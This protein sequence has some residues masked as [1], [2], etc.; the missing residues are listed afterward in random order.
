[1]V[2]EKGTAMV[3][4]RFAVPSKGLRPAGAALRP[5]PLSQFRSNSPLCVNCEKSII[6]E[7]R[8]RKGCDSFFR[9]LSQDFSRN[10]TIR[11]NRAWWRLSCIGHHGPCCEKNY[12]E[13][14][15]VGGAGRSGWLCREEARSM[16]CS[17]WRRW[18]ACVGVTHEVEDL[19]GA[20]DAV[21]RQPFGAGPLLL[22]AFGLLNYGLWNAVQS[23][24][25]PE[26][27]GGDWLGN[28]LRVIFRMQRRLEYLSCLQD[29]GR[30]AG[31]GLEREDGV[32]KRFSPGRG[33]HSRCRGARTRDPRG[34]ADGRVATS[35]VVR[36]VRGNT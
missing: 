11:A 12:R 32:M 2:P 18:R 35:L 23:I 10:A 22:L 30:G 36:L 28:A 6:G 16:S 25:D 29:R 8:T 9:T 3:A 7:S 13:G 14:E 26:R 21:A 15:A 19:A 1:M 17:A 31:A 33:R 27:V 24:W 34:G 20:V 4:S 5:S